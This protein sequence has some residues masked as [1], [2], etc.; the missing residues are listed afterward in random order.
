[1]E[2]EQRVGRGGTRDSG[3]CVHVKRP[4]G[5]RETGRGPQ[6]SRGLRGIVPFTDLGNTGKDA[7]VIGWKWGRGDEESP[8]RGSN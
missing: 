4:G 7:G 6:C 2:S 3:Q 5:E 8:S 1:M